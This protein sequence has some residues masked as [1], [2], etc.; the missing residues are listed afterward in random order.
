MQQNLLRGKAELLEKS[1]HALARALKAESSKKQELRMLRNSGEGGGGAEI[2]PLLC[3]DL[4]G[5]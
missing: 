5:N 4:T 2:A 3:S 1:A